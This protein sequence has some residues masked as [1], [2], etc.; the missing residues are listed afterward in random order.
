MLGVQ[1][2]EML[3][4]AKAIGLVALIVV[5]ISDPWW[6]RTMPWLRHVYRLNLC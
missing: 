5:C 2:A 6:V 1:P 4:V 3:M